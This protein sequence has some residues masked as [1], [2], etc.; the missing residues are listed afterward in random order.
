MKEKIPIQSIQPVFRRIYVQIYWLIGIA[1]VG[2][3]TFFAAGNY[4]LR[5]D[6]KNR[7]NLNQTILESIGQ[8]LNSVLTNP[9]ELFYTVFLSATKVTF[10]NLVANNNELITRDFELLI[11]SYRGLILQLRVL[12]EAGDEELRVNFKNG[13]AVSVAT[14]N[15]QDKSQRDYF[16]KAKQLEKGQLFISAIDL[17]REKGKIEEPRQTT[18]R[19]IAKGFDEK[20]NFRGFFVSN[21]KVPE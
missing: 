5:M 1:A 6:I 15:M 2:A 16:K 9:G 14:S 7:M 19:F 8:S 18:V 21:F 12:N 4:I 3:V 20:D 10:A 17:N 13:K 11:N